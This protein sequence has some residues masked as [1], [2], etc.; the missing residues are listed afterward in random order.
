M[1][2]LFKLRETVK[3]AFAGKDFRDDSGGTCRKALLVEPEGLPDGLWTFGKEL[4]AL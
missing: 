4:A 1:G 2:E 3:A